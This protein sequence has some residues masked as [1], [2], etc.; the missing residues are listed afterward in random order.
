[1]KCPISFVNTDEADLLHFERSMSAM[2]LSSRSRSYP[3]STNYVD[4]TEWAEVCSQAC[5]RESRRSIMPNLVVAL[6]L[7]LRLLH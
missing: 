1:M 3:C 6:L 2:R 7:C 4:R 5:S